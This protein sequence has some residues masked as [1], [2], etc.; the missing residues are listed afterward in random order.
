MKE[1]KSDISILDI[2]SPLPI[3]SLALKIGERSKILPAK[4]RITTSD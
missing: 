2:L 1:L 3:H 4:L